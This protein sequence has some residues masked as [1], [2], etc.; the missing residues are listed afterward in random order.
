MKRTLRL[1]LVG[2]VLV[3]SG[4]CTDLNITAP[5]GTNPPPPPCPG[6]TVGSGC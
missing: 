2:L 5:D 4:A 3:G 1:V 6:T